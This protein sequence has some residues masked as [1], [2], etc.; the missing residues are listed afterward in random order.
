MLASPDLNN[1]HT[2]IIL[3]YRGKNIFTVS[4][5]PNVSDNLYISLL[6]THVIHV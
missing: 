6:N 2:K 5:N 1:G 3:K 4:I